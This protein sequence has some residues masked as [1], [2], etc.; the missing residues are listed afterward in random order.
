MNGGDDGS[1]LA[2]RD[3]KWFSRQSLIGRHTSLAENL[4]E[5]VDRV[6]KKRSP[7]FETAFSEGLAYIAASRWAAKCSIL[8][9][10]YFSLGS[11]ITDA[12]GVSR[13][14]MI[15]SC[16]KAEVISTHFEQSYMIV[17]LTI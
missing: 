6:E 5:D 7:S 9:H 3:G 4:D 13:H 14:L 12:V 15:A 16:L 11:I 8:Q 1:F 2:I 17:M 10:Q